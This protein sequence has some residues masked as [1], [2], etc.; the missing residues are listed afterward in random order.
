MKIQIHTIVR[1]STLLFFMLFLVSFFIGTQLEVGVAKEAANA[2]LQEINITG[3]DF[4]RIMKNN[5][6]LGTIFLFGF[7]T[8]NISNIT[9]IVYNGIFYGI[10]YQKLQLI[11]GVNKSLWLLIP[12]G[13]IEFTGFAMLFHASMAIILLLYKYFDQKE[14]VQKEAIGIIRKVALGFLLIMLAAVIEVFVT[15]EIINHLN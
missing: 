4:L 10:F 15:P 9:L 11:Y 8:L 6:F 12:H 2:T 3:A 1:Y 13:V 5:F 7:L 14:L